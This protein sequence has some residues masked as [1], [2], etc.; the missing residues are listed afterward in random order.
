MFIYFAAPLRTIVKGLA[1][2]QAHLTNVL[3]VP[4][5]FGIVVTTGAG[6]PADVKPSPVMVA[7]PTYINSGGNKS[8]TTGL[9]ISALLE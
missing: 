8:A 7:L 6:L 9:T 2:P 5:K 4:L 1:A 3:P